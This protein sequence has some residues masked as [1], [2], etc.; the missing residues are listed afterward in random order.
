MF[1]STASWS[2]PAHLYMVSEWSAACTRREDPSSCSGNITGTSSLPHLVEGVN[3][4]AEQLRPAYA[5]TD[6]TYL[7]HA[8]SVSWRYYLSEGTQ[9]DCYN[10][11][12]VC[13]PRRQTV[14]TPQIWNPLPYF[15]TVHADGQL[16]NIQT[17]D[18]FFADAKHGTLPSVAWVV[19]D[20]THSEHPPARVSSGQS[21]VTRLINAVMRSPDWNS[22]AIFLSCGGRGTRTGYPR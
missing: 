17:V 5:W 12:E 2:L 15:D 9:P 13:T 18:H 19:P 7:L 3:A 14:G 11:Q 20:G 10:D 4:P 16:G 22:T 6:L 21:Y 1:E 8:H